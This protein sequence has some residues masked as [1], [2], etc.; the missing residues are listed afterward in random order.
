ML[1]TWIFLGW[2]FAVYWRLYEMFNQLRKGEREWKER[3]N[4]I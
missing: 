1:G 4:E 2:S 3:E